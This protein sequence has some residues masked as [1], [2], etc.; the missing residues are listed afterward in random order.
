[1]K[2]KEIIAIQSRRYKIE[3]CFR[4]LKTHFNSRPVYHRLRS[5]IKAHFLICYTALLIYRLLEVK[6]DKNGT[7]FSQYEILATLKNMNVAN[8]Q[9]IYY[10]ACYTGSDVLDS[11]E[12][13]F[14][15]RLNRK[16]YLPNTLNKCLKKS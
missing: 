5:R 6:L 13:L 3:D 14:D 8:C 9:N 10:Q 1:M 2:E 4:I 11:L 12:R 16:Y 15:L 7:H